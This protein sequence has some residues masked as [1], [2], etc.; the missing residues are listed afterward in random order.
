[1]TEGNP[2]APPASHLGVPAPP[3][4]ELEVASTGQRFANLLL[5]YVGILCFAFVAGLGLAFVSPELILN[6][7]DW[8]LGLAFQ[9]LYYLPTEAIFGR[10]PAKLITGT[11]V[12]SKE[13]SPASLPQVVGRTLARLVPFEAFSF[14]GANGRPVGWH[15]SWSGT[16]VVRCR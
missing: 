2:Y 5:D 13:G 14:L 8:V 9:L 7:N 3:S 12:V 1:M 4:G 10:S 15:D 6:A 16:R 11:R